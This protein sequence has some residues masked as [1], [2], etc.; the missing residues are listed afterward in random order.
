MKK[1]WKLRKRLFHIA[2]TRLN[3]PELVEES[4]DVEPSNVTGN[5]IFHI[6]EVEHPFN[7]WNRGVCFS[8]Q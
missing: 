2:A 3:F 4:I 6:D 7:I 8:S 5:E 1:E